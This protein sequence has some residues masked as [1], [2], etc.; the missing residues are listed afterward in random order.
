[1]AVEKSSD[2]GIMQRLTDDLFAHD[3]VIR[4]LDAVLMAES[5]DLPSDLLEVI[6]LLPPGTY[7]RQRFCDQV[8]SSISGHGWGYVYGTVE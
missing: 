6:A 5:Y 4:R 8:N 2:Y 1:M 7:T 3:E